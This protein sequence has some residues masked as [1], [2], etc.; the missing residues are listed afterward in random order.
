MSPAV[1]GHQDVPTVPLD[2]GALDSLYLL[3]GPACPGLGIQGSLSLL[4]LQ[5]GLMTL[6]VLVFQG[7][8]SLQ[9]DLFQELPQLLW[10]LVIQEVLGHLSF[11]E[12]RGARSLHALRECL[13]PRCVPSPQVC[14]G[15]L[16]DL[17]IL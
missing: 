2:Q 14:R 15:C 17:A 8:P 5:E 4:S 6:V 1:Q 12:G 7:G 13:V 10:D 9:G 11:P 3:W 16:E